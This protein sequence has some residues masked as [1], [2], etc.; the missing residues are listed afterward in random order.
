M[1]NIVVKDGLSVD[2]YFN[3]SGA[4]DAASPFLSIPADFY[5]EVS[6]GSVPKHSIV[7]KFGRNGA[8]GTSLAFIS[9]S[10]QYQS[11]I[12]ATSLEILS[13]S[14]NDTSAG[15]GARKVKVVGLNASWNE[16]TVEVT[17]NGTTAV[18]LG[19]QFI[20]VYRMYVSESGS[21]AT[22]SAPSHL[23]KITLRTSGAGATWCVIDTIEGTA[24]GFGIG[25]T[26]V[27]GYTIPNGYT[28]Y[29]LSK[30]VT[31]ESAKPA[32]IYFFKRE[33]ADDVTTPYTCV[34][35]LFEQNDGIAHPFN[36][37]LKAPLQ[38]FP[39]KTDVG[40]FAKVGT[41]TASVSTEFQLLLVQN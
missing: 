36:V 33:N 27:A 24:T 32:S 35:R 14:T 19:T 1:S 5:L 21:Y 34:M 26:Q 18:A 22:I 2:K 23:G 29:L 8:V 4:G 12:A 28:G 16:I 38:V 40:F 41:G 31:V 20:R 37:N 13:G 9:I 39:A 30:T 6:K 11:P 7:N 17:M 10:G 15:T 25:Q 3:T